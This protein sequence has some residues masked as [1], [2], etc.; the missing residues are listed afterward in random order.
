MNR[1]TLATVVSIAGL[2]WLGCNKSGNVGISE[3]S[4]N[5][6]GT[7]TEANSDPMLNKGIGPITSLTLDDEINM[8]M[9]EAGK[10][11]YDEV[12]LACHKPLE[13][14]VGPPPVGILDRR[15][16]EW[17]MNMIL[18]PTEMLEK[19]PIAKAL[20]AEY[21]FSPMANQNLTEEEARNIIEYF[22]TLK[23]EEN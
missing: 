22:R 21:N 20:Y 6:E 8:E 5:A 16:P 2:I 12:C 4:G 15:S 13:K 7:T 19:D 17:V 11:K 9:V 10:K 3:N 1:K 18:N 23:P 14:F